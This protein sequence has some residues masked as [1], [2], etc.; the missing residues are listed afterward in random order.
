[1]IAE[2]LR[3]LWKEH[4]VGDY[5]G[6]SECFDC[7]RTECTLCGV[8]QDT[9]VSKKKIN[10]QLSKNK[11]QL[12]L[13]LRFNPQNSFSSSRVPSEK[14]NPGGPSP[15]NEPSQQSSHKEYQPRD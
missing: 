12:V 13:P 14:A 8:L 10:I 1:M 5:R 3:K 7:H 15:E 11:A 4:V 6:P 2:R 9:E